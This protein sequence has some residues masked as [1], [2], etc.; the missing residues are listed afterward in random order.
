[1][2]LD[3]FIAAHT[4]QRLDFDGKFGAQCVDLV[5][6]YARDVLG[7]PIVWANAIDWWGKDATFEGWTRNVWGNPSSRP[8]RGSIIVWGANARAGTGVFGHIAVGVDPG[9]GL[10]FT[11]FDQNY[12][13][14]SACHLQRHSYDGVIGWG[15]RLKPPSPVIPPAVDPCAT[16]KADLASAQ[17]RLAAIATWAGQR[18]Q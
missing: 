13:T 11:S 12:P 17:A 4:G 9:N 2:I 5:D 6:Y 8:S 1:L 3:Q 15:D 16:V 10:S 14:G 7:I 18:P